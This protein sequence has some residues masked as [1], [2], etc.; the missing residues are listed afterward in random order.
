MY[1]LYLLI[2]LPVFSYGQ[3]AYETVASKQKA[4]SEQFQPLEVDDYMVGTPYNK[5][6]TGVAGSPFWVNGQWC[7][8]E[9]LYK[10]AFH[11]V[12]MLKYDCANGMMVTVRYTER[13]PE[14]LSL[15]QNCYPEVILFVNTILTN[16]NSSGSPKM[17]IGDTSRERFIFHSV[18]AE[19][20]ADGISSGYY[21]YRI[22]KK[23]PLMCRYSREIVASSGQKTFVQKEEFFL[24]L[25]NKLVRI[26]RVAS[27]EEAFPQWAEKIESFADENHINKLLP[28]NT[29]NTISILEFINT[30][31]AQ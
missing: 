12:T 31:S 25:D 13:G 27:L 24:L 18:S 8:A 10:G 2:L 4:T 28:M 23:I 26:K 20:S 6:Y 17:Q 19:E 14:Y 21:H 30:L 3:A 16:G 9:V 29:D 11:P 5:V 7:K 15:V 22:D 1:K